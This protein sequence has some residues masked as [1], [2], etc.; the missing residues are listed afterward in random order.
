M[1]Q[2]AYHIEGGIGQMPN[3]M[4]VGFS[5]EQIDGVIDDLIRLFPTEMDDAVYRTFP[6]DAP[7][8]AKTGKKAPYIIIRDSDLTRA[9]LIRSELQK[10]VT[11]PD[12]EVDIIKFYPG[13]G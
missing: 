1:I 3:I 11:C 7:V 13:S 6:D 4:F 9:E 2:L 8:Y 5:E 12:I 10:W